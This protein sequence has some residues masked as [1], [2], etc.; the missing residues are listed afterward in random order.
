MSFEHYALAFWIIAGFDLC[1]LVGEAT[2]TESSTILV[3]AISLPFFVAAIAFRFTCPGSNPP[4]VHQNSK[5]CFEF[6]KTKTRRWSLFTYDR[7]FCSSTC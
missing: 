7:L 3:V 5:A 2:I 6:R 4:T 1:L